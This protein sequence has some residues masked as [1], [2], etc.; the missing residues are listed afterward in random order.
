MLE[1]LAFDPNAQQ[2]SGIDRVEIFLD[3]RDDGGA[4]LGQATLDSGRAWRA[5]VTLP[6]NQTGLH[7]LS[8]YAHS[9][10]TDKESLVSVPVTIAP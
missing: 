10:L 1:G 7:T 6:S 9:S 5:V 2:G 4:M 3:N 8:F